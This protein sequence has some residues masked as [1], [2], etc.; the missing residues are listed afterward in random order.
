MD[1]LQVGILAGSRTTTCGLLLSRQADQPRIPGPPPP[2]AAKDG[3]NTNHETVRERL[4]AN[5]Q[6]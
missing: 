4:A 5:R 2:N 3:E 6:T 1:V